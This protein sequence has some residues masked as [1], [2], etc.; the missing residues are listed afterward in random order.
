[1]S[2]AT[3]YIEKPIARGD[4]AAAQAACHAEA[5]KRLGGDDVVLVDIHS[6]AGPA[7]ATTWSRTTPDAPAKVGPTKKVKAK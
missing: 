2:S 7:L 4:I 6:I 3:T 5:V 1:M